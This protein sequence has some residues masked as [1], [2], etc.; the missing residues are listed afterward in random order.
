MAIM[1]ANITLLRHFMV[2]CCHHFLSSLSTNAGG[3]CRQSFSI[4]FIHKLNF[5]QNQIYYQRE[6]VTIA[7]SSFLIFT[8]YNTIVIIHIHAEFYRGIWFSVAQKAYRLHMAR[9]TESMPFAGRFVRLDPLPFLSSRSYSGTYQFLYF[10]IP[11][12][13][14]PLYNRL[15][16]FE[17]ERKFLISS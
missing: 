16:S 9:R 10:I 1:I 2:L 14:F 8:I 15:V 17:S 5:L 7:K 13:T 6:R 12:K 3:F 4:Q 11:L